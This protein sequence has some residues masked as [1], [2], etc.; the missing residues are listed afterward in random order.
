M[1]VI[2]FRL[3]REEAGD[4]RQTLAVI[5]P[6]EFV[7]QGKADKRDEAV[8]KTRSNP[9][10]EATFRG[11]LGQRPISKIG[12]FKKTEEPHLFPAQDW[13]EPRVAKP[14]SQHRVI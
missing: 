2:F 9:V 14:L 10:N 11:K 5:G 13:D 1:R 3:S 12:L 6:G 4:I 8:G 7:R